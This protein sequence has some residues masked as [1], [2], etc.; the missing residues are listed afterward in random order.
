MAVDGMMRL[1]HESVLSH[2]LR[3][4]LS[5]SISSFARVRVGRHWRRRVSEQSSHV[6]NDAQ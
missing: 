5:L 4:P 6:L 3:S 1:C 2:E